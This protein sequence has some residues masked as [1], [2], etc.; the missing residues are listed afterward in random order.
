MISATCIC[1]CLEV[2]VGK[3]F[4]QVPGSRGKQ[5][6]GEENK[7]QQNG[8]LLE[9]L[10]AWG[11]L[12]TQ[13][14][15]VGTPQAK[16]RQQPTVQNAVDEAGQ[17]QGLTG[18]S[19]S[20]KIILVTQ[21]S[22][23]TSA[24]SGCDFGRQNQGH[25]HPFPSTPHTVIGVIGAVRRPAP[26]S[27]RLLLLRDDC[28]AGVS[29]Q[30]QG[31]HTGCLAARVC[32]LPI[33]TPQQ[34]RIFP[35]RSRI[36]AVS[37]QASPSA[38]STSTH[39][40]GTA[41]PDP[42]VASLRV[43]APAMAFTTRLQRA[44]AGVAARS[45]QGSIAAPARRHMRLYSQA[46]AVPTTSLGQRTQASIAVSPFLTCLANMQTSRHARH[47]DMPRHIVPAAG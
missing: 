42:R 12:L 1:C 13:V 36:V 20:N 14:C 6:E 34:T 35:R 2:M 5:R 27:Y 37:Q 11:H 21:S 16:L 18:S 39:A 31:V 25:P 10:S 45:S 22:S 32:G 46:A 8:Y 33:C 41:P 15:A 40:A 17:G 9:Y 26:V 47:V 28:C 43:P 30:C 23:I 7:N 29:V 44:A 3:T 38:R 24:E 4:A 19:R